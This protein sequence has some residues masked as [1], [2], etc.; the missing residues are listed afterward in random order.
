MLDGRTDKNIVIGSVVVLQAAQR[1]RR[2]KLTTQVAPTDNVSHREDPEIGFKHRTSC[3]GRSRDF[4]LLSQRY[5]A[6]IWS[7]STCKESLHGELF[8]LAIFLPFLHH[9]IR[10]RSTR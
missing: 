8:S 4:R 6:N 1:R 7:V 9:Y 3:R 2:D 10:L 5:A